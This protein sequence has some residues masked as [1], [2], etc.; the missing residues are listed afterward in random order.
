[1][2]YNGKKKQRQQTI[3]KWNKREEERKINL[4][5]V[6]SAG[7]NCFRCMCLRWFSVY[8]VS[9][10]NSILKRIKHIFIVVVVVLR[11]SI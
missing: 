10:K 1:M 9:S 11:N 6:H 5:N 3:S 7:L 2:K 8:I 4:L